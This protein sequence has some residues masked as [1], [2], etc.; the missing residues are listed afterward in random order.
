MWVEKSYFIRKS[1]M[2]IK[3]QHIKGENCYLGIFS[4]DIQIPTPNPVYK[5]IFHAFTTPF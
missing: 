1:F 3:R 2:S 5:S 4:S